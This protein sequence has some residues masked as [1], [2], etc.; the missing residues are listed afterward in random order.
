[1]EEASTSAAGAARAAGLTPLIIT[2]VEAQNLPIKDVAAKTDPFVAIEAGGVRAQTDVQRGTVNPIFDHLCTL[3]CV[4]SAGVR[5]ELRI[6]CWHEDVYEDVLI[7]R[8]TLD[9]SAVIHEH[10]ELDEVRPAAPAPPSRPPARPTSPEGLPP[11]RASRHPLPPRSGS[12]CSTSAA[13][14]PSAPTCTCT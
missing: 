10:A 4:F 6:A 14:R 13:S 5:E 3:R 1:M 8:G 7:G 11:L 12:S 2:I 9:I